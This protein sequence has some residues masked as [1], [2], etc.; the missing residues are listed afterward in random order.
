[1]FAQYPGW[2]VNSDGSVFIATANENAVGVYTCTA[3]NSYG[4]MGQSEPTRVILKVRGVSSD[5]L[6]CRLYIQKRFHHSFVLFQDPP[7]FRVAPRSEYLQDVGRELMIDCQAHGDPS[8]NI[9]WTKVATL[10][11]TITLKTFSHGASK[12]NPGSGPFSQIVTMT[13]LCRCF[14]A[15]PYNLNNIKLKTHCS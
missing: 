10:L 8:P 1:M 3:Y 12:T 5:S 7:S 13:T 9:T 2:K 11:V 6:L 4:T 14:R 15:S